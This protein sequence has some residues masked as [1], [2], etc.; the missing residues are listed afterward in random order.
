M[1]EPHTYYLPAFLMVLIF[2]AFVSTTAFGIL[3]KDY[4]LETCSQP[5]GKDANLKIELIATD[6][7]APSNMVFL[8]K[9]ILARTVWYI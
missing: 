3:P 8:D 7:N 6:L 9:D 5:I 1:I 2:L 4:K